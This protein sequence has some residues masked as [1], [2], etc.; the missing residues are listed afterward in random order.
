MHDDQRILESF[1][2]DALRR[3]CLM[4]ET[5]FGDSYEMER[6]KIDQPGPEDYYFFRDNGSKILA[7]A[8]LDTVV[9][10]D[11][12]R[13]AYHDTDDGLVIQSGS[14]DDRLGAYIILE[15]LPRLGLEFDVLLTVGEESGCS[16]ASGFMT[17]K[18]YNWIIEFD[19]GGMDVVTYE[20]ETPELVDMVRSVGAHHAPGIFS[21]ISYM[22]HVG[23]KALNWGVAYHDY[24]GPNGYAYLDDTFE[25]LAMFLD[26]HRLYGDTRMPHTERV[27]PARTSSW[28]G[29]SWIGGGYAGRD[30]EMWQDESIDPM[31]DEDGRPIFADDDGPECYDEDG[32]YIGPPPIGPDDVVDY[33]TPEQLRWAAAWI[34]D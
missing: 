31:W 13:V 23:V 5:S 21:D 27:R 12:R 22:E 28:W 10:P 24:H 11:D 19:R 30:E 32:F 25:M 34:N 26:F 8:H 3:V 14:L 17:D 16:T 20:Y 2:R 29:D 4:P 6:V 1:D 33:P 15:L 18:D 7:V 9:M